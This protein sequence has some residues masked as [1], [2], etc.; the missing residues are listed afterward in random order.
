MQNSEIVTA[1]VGRFGKMRAV[2]MTLAKARKV[3]ESEGVWMIL[4]DAGRHVE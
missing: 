4:D 1:Y 2:R 3:Q